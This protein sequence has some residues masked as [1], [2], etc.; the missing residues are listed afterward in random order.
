MPRVL[1][2]MLIVGLSMSCAIVGP[3]P[4]AAAAVH[5]GNWTVLIVTEKG[6][7]DR[8]YR[9]DLKVVNGHVRYQGESSVKFTGTVAPNGAVKVSI[10]L[11]EQGANGTGRLSKNTGVGIWR[12]VGPSA[13]C[14]GRWQAERR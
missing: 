12:G 7:C 3:T 1:D 5:D 6:T 13:E 4:A 8:A 10:R 14:A 11:G 2:I 9:Y